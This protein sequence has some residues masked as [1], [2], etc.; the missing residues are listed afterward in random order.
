MESDA[1]EP[2]FVVEFPF[3]LKL[4]NHRAAT[5]TAFALHQIVAAAGTHATMLPS[6]RQIPLYSQRNFKG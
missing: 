4:I 5:Y 2:K 1:L 6:I 3:T